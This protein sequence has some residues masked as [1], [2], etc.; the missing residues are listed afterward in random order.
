MAVCLPG[1]TAVGDKCYSVIRFN[2]F[3]S[4]FLQLIKLLII[5]KKK[6]P[7]LP[8]RYNFYMS[9][10]LCSLAQ[11]DLFHVNN[12]TQWTNLNA[13]LVDTLGIKYCFINIS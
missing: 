6:V 13:F 3:F 2:Y 9:S 8:Q 7:G 5:K 4:F 10:E 1:Y 12:I 11:G